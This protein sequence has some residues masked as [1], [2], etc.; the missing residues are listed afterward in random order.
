[1]PKWNEAKVV[2][3]VDETASTKRFFLEPIDGGAIDFVPGQFITLDLPIHEVRQKRWRSYSIANAPSDDGLLELCIV[4]LEGGLGTTY[5]FESIEKD[6]IIK[7]KAPAGVF[8]LRK[9]IERD[10]VLICTGTGVAPFRSMIHDIYNQ[11]I[12]HQKI[13]LIFGTR[14]NVDVLYLDEFAHLAHKQ[15]SFSYTVSLSREETLTNND[16]DV[17]WLKGYVHQAY[18]ETYK[19]LREDIQFLICGWQNMVDEAEAKLKGMGYA[20]RQVKVELYG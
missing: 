16:S 18:E 11:N 12:P 20:D 8:T 1:M 6:S 9:P 5:L 3:I 10:L 17:N 4:K 13:H 14:T 19:D 7:Y 15:A 2:K